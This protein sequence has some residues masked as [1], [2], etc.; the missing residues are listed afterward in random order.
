MPKFT[1]LD[2]GRARA[3]RRAQYFTVMSERVDGWVS[4]RERARAPGIWDSALDHMHRSSSPATKNLKGIPGALLL[5][6]WLRMCLVQGM[7]VQFPVREQR[8]HRL[9]SN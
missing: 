9:W 4:N 2:S 3:R 5:V 6:Q 8:P 1:E 7:W